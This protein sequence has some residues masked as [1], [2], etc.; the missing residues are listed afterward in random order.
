MKI[1]DI[2]FR[3]VYN[4]SYNIR[5]GRN[6]FCYFTFKESYKVY[7]DAGLITFKLMGLNQDK[8]KKLRKKANPNILMEMEND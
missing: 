8:K 6:K 5:M 2:N 4:L 3:I 1:R 7:C